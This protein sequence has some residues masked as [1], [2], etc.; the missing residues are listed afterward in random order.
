MSRFVLLALILSLSVSSLR[1]EEPITARVYDVATAQQIGTAVVNALASTDDRR[2]FSIAIDGE[3]PADGAP[4]DVYA[5]GARVNAKRL[6]LARKGDA[7][8]LVLS[9]TESDRLLAAEQVAIVTPTH[10]IELAR[11]QIERLHEAAVREGVR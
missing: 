11:E 3:G 10:R 5:D 7:L 4:A 1:A 8:E 9:A 2:R 6:R